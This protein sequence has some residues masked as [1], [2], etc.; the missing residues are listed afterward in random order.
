M[1]IYPLPS[2]KD[3]YI[4]LIQD[5][6]SSDIWVVD[7]GD[8]KPVQTHCAKHN[9]TI[10]GIIVTHHHWDHTN[11]ILALRSKFNCPVYGPK[12]LHP[13]LISHPLKEGDTVNIFE[14]IFTVWE[15]PGHTLDHLCYVDQKDKPLIFCGDTVF[16]GGCGRLMEGTATQML[17]AI[18]RIAALDPST[19][20]YATHEYTLVNYQFAKSLEPTNQ[21]LLNNELTCRELRATSTPTLP[22]T[23]GLENETNPFFR[24]SFS[25]VVTAA[26]RQL[27][28]QPDQTP[29]GAF[30]Q[31]RRAKDVF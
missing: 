29:D 7:P 30:A 23:V 25:H 3:N 18:S 13:K 8:A 11:G 21:Q 4:W 16:R 27:D 19:L 12:H 1:T 24:S 28:E 17:T 15:I 22:T 10:K 2:L 14:R 31:I 26:A 20:V 5:N 9:L 6:D